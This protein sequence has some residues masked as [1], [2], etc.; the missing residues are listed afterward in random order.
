M[1]LLSLWS[2][3]TSRHIWLY[4]SREQSNA[5]Q[6]SSGLKIW[7]VSGLWSSGCS[8]QLAVP[9]RNLGR[10]SR[11]NTRSGSS[12]KK[13]SDMYCKCLLHS[14]TLTWNKVWCIQSC[15]QM[16][17]N[18][19]ENRNVAVVDKNFWPFKLWWEHIL[20]CGNNITE[21]LEPTWSRNRGWLECSQSFP[22]KSRKIGTNLQKKRSKSGQTLQIQRKSGS[23]QIR[24]ISEGWNLPGTRSGVICGIT[25]CL[26]INPRNIE[27][28]LQK[29]GQKSG[30]TLQI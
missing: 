23:K 7:G 3:F 30:Q 20:T 10:N 4:I 17:K 28:N 25:K 27:I 12:G 1:L 29:S 24:V 18:N 8:E 16:L 9:D 13:Q 2:A 14:S 15:F 19:T 21:E 26:R 6:V 5:K 11:K 22:H